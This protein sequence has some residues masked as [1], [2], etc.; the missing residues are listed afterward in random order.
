MQVNTDTTLRH[1]IEAINLLLA[2]QNILSKNTTTIRINN[3]LVFNFPHEP[4]DSQSSTHSSSNADNQVNDHGL[5]ASSPSHPKP[6]APQMNCDKLELL[7]IDLRKYIANSVIYWKTKISE[8]FKKS[9]F[10]DVDIF[11]LLLLSHLSLVINVH[12]CVFVLV[13]VCM[14]VVTREFQ[15]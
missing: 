7:L 15:I 14:Y 1:K 13:C 10:D 4:A 3:M 5:S 11:G 8:F 9:K 6:H 2:N 12:M